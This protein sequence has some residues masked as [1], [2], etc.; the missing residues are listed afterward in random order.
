MLGITWKCKN[1]NNEVIITDDWEFYLDGSQKRKRYGYPVPLSQEGV[2][3]VKGFSADLYCPK[4]KDVR[5]VIIEEF[6]KAAKQSCPNGDK[7]E[8]EPVCNICGTKV[9]KSLNDSDL[10]PKCNT[11]TF[12]LHNI[13]TS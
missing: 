7:L 6:K 3:G 2:E 13:W 10:C 5:D 8:I 9:K 4:C 12:K 1:C 11:G